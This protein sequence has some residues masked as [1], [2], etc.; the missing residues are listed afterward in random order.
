MDQR[1]TNADWLQSAPYRRRRWNTDRPVNMLTA[2]PQ[3]STTY[4]G[5]LRHDL[6]NHNE[7]NPNASQ[8]QSVERRPT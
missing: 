6:D 8:S 3:K 7:I 2:T 4:R 1:T 5:Q